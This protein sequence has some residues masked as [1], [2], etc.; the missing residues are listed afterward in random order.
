MTGEISIQQ[1]VESDWDAFYRCMSDAFNEDVEEE[2]S[3]AERLIFE[4]ERALVA[5]RGT[6]IVGT[7]GV[8]TRDLTIP[9]GA[10]A[11]AH[12]TFVTVAATARRQGVLTQM[13]KRQFADIAAAG[14][15]L[16]VLWASEARIYQRFGYGIGARRLSLTIESREI[17]LTVPPAGKGTLREGAPGQLR[18]AMIA[19]YDAVLAERPGWSTRAARHWDYRL[20]DLA[21][22]RRSASALR[23][24]VY[25]GPDGP[26]GYAYY[27]VS[28]KWSESGPASEIRLIELVA[29]T[30]EAYQSLWRFF[31]TLDLTRSIDAWITS[32]DEPL[33]FMANEPRRLQARIT[34]ALWVRLVDVAGALSAR[35]YAAPI[36]IVI[37]VTDEMIPANAGQWHL[38]GSPTEATCVPTTKDPDLACDVRVLGGAY[39]GAV[40]LSSFAAAGMLTQLLPG[41][42]AAATTAFGWPQAASA[43]EVF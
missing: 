40:P 20:A 17:S 32:I 15:P 37:D 43:I 31:L 25:D 7:A 27:R 38:T 11:A 28:G 36:D 5:R 1:V 29:V 23:G 10:V 6:E 16:A 4:P 12:V 22:S 26:E 42:V 30:P 3:A 9:G 2:G 18:E 41:A 21:T 14:E 8:L 34:D 24:V 39:L 19:V 13:M 35:R 33:F